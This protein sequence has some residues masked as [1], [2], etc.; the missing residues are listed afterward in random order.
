MTK[1]TT[2]RRN[3]LPASEFA[4][5]ETKQYPIDTRRRA[6]NA[7]GRAEQMENKGKISM[8]TKNKIDKKANKVLGDGKPKN[9]AMANAMNA[10]KKRKSTPRPKIGY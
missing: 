4:L 9:P 2:K 5:P 3:A 8:S 10:A 6:I 7:K 1:L